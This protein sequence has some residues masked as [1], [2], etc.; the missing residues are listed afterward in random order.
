[1]PDCT[2]KILCTDEIRLKRRHAML[3]KK[4]KITFF[5][6]FEEENQPAAGE[7]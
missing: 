1:M 4:N 2:A 6:D 7:D 3:S 5:A